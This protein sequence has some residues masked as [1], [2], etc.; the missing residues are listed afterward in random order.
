MNNEDFFPILR[1]EDEELSDFF[2]KLKN[3]NISVVN[4]YGIPMVDR[5]NFKKR[6]A[7]PEK[8]KEI[9]ERLDL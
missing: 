2:E 4:E 8:I 9:A 7:S 1:I 5:F 6:K 3:K